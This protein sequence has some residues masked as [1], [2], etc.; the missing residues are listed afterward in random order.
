MR[1]ISLTAAALL[2]ALLAPVAAHA[3][4]ADTGVAN[5]KP[6][7][8]PPLATK[9]DPTYRP[10]RSR[11]YV[12]RLLVPAG[13]YRKA[14]A[15]EAMRTLPPWIPSTG[16]SVVLQVL[17]RRVDSD[18]KGWLMVL[19]P[20]RPNGSTAWI[21]EETA[22]VYKDPM[23]IVISTRRHLLTV[24]RHGKPILRVG[25]A[26][27]AL[28]TPTPRGHFAIYQKIHEPT[29]SPLGPWALHLTA[30]SNVLLEYD[31]GAGRVA[32]HGA[33]GALWAQAGT[34]V[35]HGCIRV[36]DGNIARVAPLV[37]AG[38]P[39]DIVG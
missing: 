39:V 17:A 24:Y 6:P 21:R 12:A 31:G 35:S 14:G 4:D 9:R 15:R 8:L 23:H 5:G 37:H 16:L 33:R 7:K 19:L 1:R 22:A 13:I 10:T 3:Q 36:P 26:L 34:N 2:L 11:T 29:S 27:G 38:T 30:H 32:I 20:Y 25:V 28:E 18:G